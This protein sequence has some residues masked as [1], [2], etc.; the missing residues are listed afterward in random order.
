MTDSFKVGAEWNALVHHRPRQNRSDAQTGIGDLE[1]TTKSCFMNIGGQPVHAGLPFDLGLP[2]GDP[3]RG[4][5]EGTI[6]YAPSLLFGWELAGLRRLT[7]V[8]QAGLAFL[9]ESRGG[10]EEEE[11]PAHEYFISAGA[12]LPIHPL[13]FSLECGW[14]D[15]RWN[16]GGDESI[17]SLTPGIHWKPD[18]EWQIGLGVSWGLNH[19][20]DKYRIAFLFVR[21]F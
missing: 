9:Q 13:I 5:G 20:A 11:S 12:L 17:L 8:S 21:E 4:L 15:N 1:L 3:G 10:D 18:S 16:R 7:L 6:E 19:D 14:S 2:T